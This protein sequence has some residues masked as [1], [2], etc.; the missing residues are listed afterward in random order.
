VPQGLVLGP[1]LFLLYI[2]DLPL[3]IHGANLVMFTDVISM[4]ATDGDVCALQRK[5]YTVMA[6][7]EIWFNNNDLIVNIGKTGVVLFH[8]R[9][10]KFLEKPQV[11]FNKI[12]LKYTA[13]MKFLGVYITEI[14]KWNSHVQSLTSKL[15]KISFLIKSSM[16]TLS[17]SPKQCCKTQGKSPRC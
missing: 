14:L 4:L 10:S 11:S 1:L 9:Q 3:N 12:K 2:N 8:N 17:L 13:E 7:L 5:M 6:E 15:S 16:G